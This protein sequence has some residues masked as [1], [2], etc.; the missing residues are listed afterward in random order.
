MIDYNGM[1]VTDNY[2][3]QRIHNILKEDD[4]ELGEVVEY[5]PD[6]LHP[7]G[8]DD[9][10]YLDDLSDTLETLLRKKLSE[11]EYKVVQLL[12][13]QEKKR[14]ESGFQF[15]ITPTRIGQI[16]ESALRKMRQNLDNG[17]LR[18]YL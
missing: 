18:E 14:T 11:R 10:L 15:D 9:D 5:Y 16:E 8:F 2:R 1:S 3:Y 7:S 13:F 6:A 12:Y 17:P 4:I